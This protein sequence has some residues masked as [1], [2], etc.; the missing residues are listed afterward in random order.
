MSMSVIKTDGSL[1]PIPDDAID[2]LRQQMRGSL[3]TVDESAVEPCPPWNAMHTGR[4]A[5]T[6]RCTGTADVVDAVN[7]ARDNELLLGVR[8]GGHSVAGL[9]TVNLGMLI[10][11]SAMRGVQ[12]DPDRRLVHVQ[13]GAVLGDVD[14][15]TQAFGLATPLGR[16]SET[17]VAGLTLGGGYG[18]LN[19]AYGLSCDNLVAA[20]VVCADGT[21]HTASAE[22]EPDLLWALRGGGGNFGVVTSFTFQL[23]PVG[24][25]VGFAGVFYPLEDLGRVERAWR[26]YADTAPD[27]V[28]TFIVTMTFPAAAEMPEV[29]HNRP[30]AI[31]GA[32]HAGDA[33][34]GMRI[35]QPLRELGTPLFDLSQP[36]PYAAVQ[37][38]FDPFFPRQTLRAYWKSQYLDELTD[39]AI[40]A[41]VGRANDRPGPMTLVNTFRLGGAVN[42]VGPEETAFAERSA[43]YMVSIDT[44]WSDP[45]EDDAAISWG[46]AAFE[47][48]TKYGNG[49]VFL[50]FTGRAGEPLQANVDSAF[51]RNLARLGRIKATYDRDNLF[52]LNN[53]ILPQG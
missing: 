46:R 19:G 25:I 23:R 16:V 15:E 5:L 24:P 3:L 33:D 50:N 21:V 42:R 9:S 32:V 34:E 26:E 48:M 27:E 28:T 30:V 47:E 38:A 31:V 41:I 4:A 2:A 35:L 11:L 37:A 36:M 39:D 22:T 40:D 43:P 18:H 29:I 7:F 8:G 1:Q 44:M 10:D 6:A 17:G 12:V 45:A 52:Q 51:G 14:R 13:G 49:S 53:N 20:Q